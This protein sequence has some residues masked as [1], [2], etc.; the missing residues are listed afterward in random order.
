L[1]L[2]PALIDDQPNKTRDADYLFDALI[3]A[4]GW[5]F[6]F[7]ARRDLVLW[8]LGR[9]FPNASRILEAGC[10]AGFVLQG[11]RRQRPQALLAGCDASL[12][13]IRLAR[14]RAGRAQF[15]QADVR[16]LPVAPTFDIVIALDVIEHITEDERVLVQLF[17]TI[18]PGG[19]CVL[20]VPQHQWLWSEVDE[21]SHHRRRYSRRDL[22]EKVRRAGFEILRDTSFFTTTLPLMYAARRRRSRPFDPRA[23]LRVSRPANAM[24]RLLLRPEWFLI[25]MGVSLPA[26]GSL[27]VVARRP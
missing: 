17:D 12:H 11:I 7:N 2:Q 6:W 27:L 23:E 19:G 14:A 13:A 20:T 10:G 8:I 5:H 4:E 9:H 1:D 18:R 16:H 26:G 15:F 22:L 3:D 24:L 25:R 21:F